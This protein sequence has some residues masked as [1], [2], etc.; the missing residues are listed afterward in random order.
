MFVQHEL[1]LR[2]LQKRRKMH[3]YDGGKLLKYV[4]SRSK[5]LNYVNPFTTERPLK[6]LN[7]KCYGKN[8]LNRPKILDQGAPTEIS[9]KSINYTKNY[10]L[11]SNF[12]RGP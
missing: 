2:K 4:V 6:I 1:L 12:G 11:F 5:S 7:T 8:Y 9:E 3:S 10:R